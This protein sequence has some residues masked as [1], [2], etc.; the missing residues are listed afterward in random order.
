MRSLFAELFR[1]DPVLA[2]TGLLHAALLLVAFTLSFVDATEVMGINVWVKP[3]KF[4]AS[5]AIYLWTV[6]WFI[7]Y[8]PGPKWALQLFAWGASATMVLESVCLW[9]QAARGTHSHFNNATEF[10]AAIFGAMGILIL[11]NG[12]LDLLLLFLFF[13]KRF[14]IPRVYLWSIRIGLGVFLLGG[15]E[16]MVMIANNGHA[17]GVA[18]GGPGLPFLNWSVE[19]GDLRVAHMLGLH[20]LQVIPLFGFAMAR[21]LP[22]DSDFFKILLLCVFALSYTL[23]LALAFWQAMNGQALV[24]LT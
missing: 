20:A 7:A 21:W 10:D 24:T 12:L 15:L 11:A 5:I 9:I 2:R 14:D 23:L 4:M 13:Q 19:G 18:D 22:T 1:R 16:G 6:A 17:V 3:M 8:L